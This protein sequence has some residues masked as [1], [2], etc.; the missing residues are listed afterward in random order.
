M[1]TDTELLTEIRDL[2]AIMAEP[3]I[4]ERDKRQRQEIK[5]LVGRRPKAQAAV[6]LMDGNRKQSEITKA[7]GFHQG[8]LSKLVKELVSGKLA[9]VVDGK[10]RLGLRLPPGLF[11]K[12]TK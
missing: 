4:A 2:L 11:D 7:T 5:E 12:D 10:P 3:Q 8:D 9:T 1:P 6:Y